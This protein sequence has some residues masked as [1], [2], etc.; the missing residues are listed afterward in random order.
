MPNMPIVQPASS[1]PAEELAKSLAAKFL[2]NGNYDA[3]R[4]AP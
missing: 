3:L 4:H 2:E 1:S